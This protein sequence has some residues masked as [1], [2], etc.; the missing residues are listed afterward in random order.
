MK[1]HNK[2]IADTNQWNG[3]FGKAT[4]LT[5]KT[6]VGRQAVADELDMRLSPE[7]LSCD[8][9]VGGASLIKKARY[10][11]ACAKELLE[12]D[13]TVQMWEYTA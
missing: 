8:G 3:L 12:L 13:P 11:R 7:N 2:F 9:E 1:N 4:L 6:A 10:L 5:L